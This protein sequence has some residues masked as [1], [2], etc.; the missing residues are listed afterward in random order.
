MKKTFR[1]LL[2]DYGLEGLQD[3]VVQKEIEFTFYVHVKDLSELENAPYKEKH[4]Q[5]KLPIESDGNKRLRIR[6]TDDRRAELTT[7]IQR[8]GVVG[9]EE[10]NESIGIPMFSH[11]RE[12][13]VSGYHKYRYSFPIHGTSLKWEV[14]VFMNK[15]GKQH[16]WVKVDLEVS[17]LDME[18]PKM[19]FAFTD[20]ICADDENISS[21]D[22]ATIDSLWK[23]EWM[24]IG[25]SAEK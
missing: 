12:M 20:F 17:D 9:W 5:W 16:P 23:N 18:I 10:I 2:N 8:P 7:K 1:D 21:D 11:L 22:K 4:E 3:G 19:P 25:D 6:L 24:A 13:S 15:M 14:D